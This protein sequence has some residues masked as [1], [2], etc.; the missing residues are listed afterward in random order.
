MLGL[1]YEIRFSDADETT[2]PGLAPAA[3]VE[4]LALRKALTVHAA[5]QTGPGAI[6][7]ADTIVVVDGK[8]LGKPKDDDEACAMLASLQGRTH[9]VYSGVA[10]VEAGWD[11]ADGL[12]RAEVRVR[13]AEPPDETV[14]PFAGF[15][16]LAADADSPGKPLM[17][18][19]HSVSR[20]TFRPMSGEEIRAYAATGEPRDKAGAYAV[21]GIGAI[22]VERLEGDFFSV[23]GLPL[24]LLYPMLRRFGFHPLA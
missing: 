18:S 22:F 11:G 10:L 5:A 17:L 15:R 2:E 20:V 16:R 6:L 13:L 1:P 12:D 23:M 9:E 3:I 21:Q 24:S 14:G 7:G 4:S 19:G 8:V